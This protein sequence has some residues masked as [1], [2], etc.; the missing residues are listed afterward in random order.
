M[1]VD[2]GYK[3]RPLE[4]PFRYENFCDVPDRSLVLLNSWPRLV[5]G[6]LDPVP[7]LVRLDL[8]GCELE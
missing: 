7:D 8:G 6:L 3:R 5:V 4:D 1:T 2:L